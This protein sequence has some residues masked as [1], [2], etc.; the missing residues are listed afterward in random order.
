MNQKILYRIQIN[1]L[2]SIF[3]LGGTLA[4]T[5][6]WKFAGICND[7]VLSIASD[8]HGHI[9]AGTGGNG[10]YRSTDAGQ[11][12]VN[13][14]N[15]RDRVEALAVDSND[16]IFAGRYRSTDEGV[17]WSDSSFPPGVPWSMYTAPN[18]DLFAGVL[19]VESY[20]GGLLYWSRDNGDHWTRIDDDLLETIPLSVLQHSS[21]ALL[22]GGVW[23]DVYVDKPPPNQWFFHGGLRHSVDSGNT[24]VTLQ[25][26]H[27]FTASSVKED[28]H[29]WIFAGTWWYGMYRSIDSGST[30][31]EINQGLSTLHQRNIRSSVINANGNI[32]L[33]TL[34]GVF[35]STDDGNNWVAIN[36]GLTDTSVLSITVDPDG[37]VYVGTQAGVF[38]SVQSTTSVEHLKQRNFPQFYLKQNYPNPFNASTT[39]EFTLPYAAFVTLKV[40]NSLGEEIRSLI[41]QRR[42]AGNLSFRWN[43]GDLPSGVYFYRLTADSYL[44]TKKLTI[45]K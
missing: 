11:S 10:V 25:G 27:D 1:F 35:R 22:V 39:I 29:G 14:Y 18:G 2:L 3:F 6:Y 20:T 5:D 19:D 44:D 43:S 4:Q 12:W 30:W 36:N 9:F 45:I 42:S 26:L 7:G 31:I 8:S 33:A 24:W 34:A 13:V 17:T 21:G 15:N 40:Y 32:F 38:R 23:L 28:Q 41:S 37:Y 16:F